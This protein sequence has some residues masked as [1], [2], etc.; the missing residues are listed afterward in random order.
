MTDIPIK[1]KSDDPVIS[2]SKCDGSELYALQVLGVDMEEEF[3][4]KCI[5]V[6]QQFEAKVA[7]SYVLAEVEDGTWFRQY[8]IDSNG[9]EYLYACNEIYPDIEL[10]NIDW[11]IKG[12]IRQRNMRRKIKT[13]KYPKE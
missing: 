9:R 1:F 13:Y 12:I 10:N 3:P 2:S 5:I 8:K 4:D 11:K 7:D 6:I